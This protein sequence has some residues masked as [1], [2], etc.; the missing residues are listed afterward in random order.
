MKRNLKAQ[1]LLMALFLFLGTS[2]VKAKGS[3]V[4]VIANQAT[5]RQVFAQIEKQS[6]YHVSYRSEMV[7]N[8]PRVTLNLKKVPVS[9]VLDAAL[10]GSGL[11][12]EIVSSTSIVIQVKKHT[13]QAQQDSKE[14]K[15]SSL[16]RYSGTITDPSGEP[17]IGATVSV[18][19]KTL[20]ISDIDGRFSIDAAQGSNLKIS[21]VGYTDKTVIAGT[22]S[23]LSI[24][25]KEDNKTLNEVVVVGYGTQKKANLTGSVTTVKM[26]D[27]LGD[28]PLTKASDA[29]LGVAPGLLAGSNGNAPGASRSFQMRGAY[30]IGSG[31]TISPLVLIDNVE[32]T[33]DMLNPEDIESVTILKDAASSA[34][35][36][37]RAAGGVILI[38]TKHPQSNSSFRLNYNN[39]IAFSNAINLPE[40]VDLDTYLEA[41]SESAGDQYW[42]IGSPSVKRWRELLAQYK[43][44]PS[45]LQT[46]GDGMYK[47]ANG[48]VYFLNEHDPFKKM[49]E[50]SF[51]QTH[52]I[53]ASGGTK[54]I[55]YRLSAGY[56]FTNGV[57]VTN[58]DEYVRK[59]I[60]GFISADVTSWLT[61]E[62]TFSYAR[63][64][65]TL[66]SS[67]LGAIYST[68]LPSFYPEGT[69]PAE[70][71][72]QSA[73]VP[74][75]TS[76]NQIQWSNASRSLNSNPRIFLRSIIK[77]FKNFDVNVEYTYDRKDYDYSWYTGSQK[78]TTVQGGVDTTPTLDYLQKQKS[79]TNY[80]AFNI[81]GTYRL[82]IL[83][84]HHF[85]FMAGF[86]QESSSYDDMVDT[87][88]GQAVI[89]VPS[90]G[91][92]TSTLIAKDNYR[93]YSVRGGF[94]RVN[95]NYASRYLLEV[96]GR[97]DG[98]SKF[99]K[100]HRFGFFP[101]VSAG[102][103]IAEESFMKTT[104]KWLDGLKLRAS[105]GM[106]GNQ[107]ISPYAFVPTMTINNKYS[108]WLIDGQYTTAVTTL[109]ELVSS[110]FTWEKVHT[111][112]FGLDIV[113]LNNRLTATI[114]WYQRNTNGMLAP[115]MQLPAVIGAKAPYQNT[116]D[117]RTRGWEISAGWHDK[118]GKVRYNINLN[119]SD[120]KSKIT[121][122]DSN[123]SKLLSGY[124]EGEQ[125]GEIWG[126][127]YDGF[128]TVDDFEDTKSWKLKEGISKP[129]GI[130]PR[131]G[132]IK[133]KNLMDDDHG[134]NL[135]T[136]GDNTLK[137]PGDRVRIGNSLPRYLFGLTLGASYQGFSFSLFMQ[138]TGKRDAWIANTLTLPM[139]S[140]YKFIALYKGLENYWKPVDEA[141]GDYACANPGAKF[142]RIYGDYA[143]MSSNYRVSDR[144]LSNAAYLRIKNMTLSYAFPKSWINRL[145]L[146]QLKLF[147]SIENLATFTSLKKGIDP[148]TLSWNYPSKRTFSFGVN[149]TL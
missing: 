85:K 23:Q 74:F 15:S 21:Y 124:Y 16:R 4:T 104:R 118:I 125:L 102:W 81:Y 70:I 54:N 126:Y 22:N 31:S 135:I 137:N 130:N 146:Y 134:T 105:Y 32:G 100:D 49:M 11:T 122:Y 128:Y 53:S 113:A 60:S 17:V 147:M 14:A 83:K 79:T 132:D 36:G 62:A 101:S 140:D 72:E 58:K 35:Y 93:D 103:N 24:S 46:Y 92:G 143:N 47:D 82:D 149:V 73:G 99:P 7:D 77:P 117:M 84:D 5:L 68:R 136:Q 66:P 91:G 34:I 142:A 65:S 133:F 40:Q 18:N 90:L 111:L 95:Y 138:G 114:D 61:Q 121:K 139:Y 127:K 8:A 48:A 110:N 57:L 86:N 64:K 141:N 63:S 108:G 75:F 44:D 145:S 56:T 98:S 129:D 59:N 20:A 109:P 30:S 13:S 96:N 50:T 78:Y 67:A 115:G 80:N 87:S 106:I 28:R 27:A 144:F 38:T 97:Y 51:Q 148:E 71:E 19:G 107:N 116:A 10:E 119:L 69:M 26:E 120:Y 94:F 33:M 42:T 39:N 112:D 76:Y 43:K 55:R 123:E 1:Y 25:L 6:S 37:A 88:Y 12:Y 45:S 29:L 131:P 2:F 89:E 41:Y 3:V 9:R 52:N